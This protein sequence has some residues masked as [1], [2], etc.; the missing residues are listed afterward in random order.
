MREKKIKSGTLKFQHKSIEDPHF[1]TNLYKHK[2]PLNL[3]FIGILRL[4]F[5][6]LNTVDQDLVQEYF[7]RNAVYFKVITAAKSGEKYFKKLD[8]RK[9]PRVEQPKCLKISEDS[10]ELIQSIKTFQYLDKKV[11]SCKVCEHL[12]D[13]ETSIQ[14]HVQNYHILPK[15]RMSE[16]DIVIHYI[17]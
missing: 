1:C 2:P 14:S 17:D 13:S 16:Q 4:T 9:K 10:N 3:N 8:F 12:T 5:E 15:R 6:Q 11:F 7:R